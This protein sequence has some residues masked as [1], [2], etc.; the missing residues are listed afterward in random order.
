MKK[1]ILFVVTFL[2]QLFFGYLAM[3]LI[4]FVALSVVL[5]WLGLVGPDNVNPWWNT[6]LTFTF[7]ALSAAFGVW[8]AGASIAR[9]RSKDTDSVKLFWGSVIGAAIG[10]GIIGIVLF[11]Q[12]AVGFWPLFAA[13]AGAVVGFYLWPRI[14]K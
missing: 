14:K 2:L 7:L 4:T 8:Y 1:S 11:F 5:E 9:A 10:V 13:L 6:P 12:P 3:F